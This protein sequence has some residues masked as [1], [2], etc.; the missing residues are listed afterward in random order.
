MARKQN[1][2]NISNS[3]NE[4]DEKLYNKF[5]W[6]KINKNHMIIPKIPNPNLDSKQ[7]NF[8]KDSKKSSSFRF[9]KKSPTLFEHIELVKKEIDAIEKSAALYKSRLKEVFNYVSRP[10]ALKNS[11]NSVM[12]HLFL[13]SNNKTAEKI[14]NDIVKK[15]NK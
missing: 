6:N 4:I 13:T 1:D 8:R 3:N 11:T 5:N 14:G 2:I 7:Q 10:Y 12:Y 9:Y 15:Y